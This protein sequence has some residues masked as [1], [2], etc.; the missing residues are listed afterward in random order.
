MTRPTAL[1]ALA[2]AGCAQSGPGPVLTAIDSTVNGRPY[3]AMVEGNSWPLSLDAVNCAGYAAWK[4]ALLKLNHLPASIIIYQPPSGPAHAFVRSG[5]W[6]LD[7][8]GPSPRP[9]KEPPGSYWEADIAFTAA[10]DGPKW[11]K[12][13]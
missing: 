6:I 10:W 4:Y 11:I 9:W 5:D 3:Q 2:L 1:L 7:S 13:Q 12:R 8:I